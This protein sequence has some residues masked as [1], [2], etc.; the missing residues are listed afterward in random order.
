VSERAAGWVAWSASGLALAFIACAVALSTLNGGSQDLAFL[1]GEATGAL[2]GGLV[3]SRQPRNPVGW[4]IIGHAL[5]FTFGEFARQYAIYGILTEPGSLPAARAMASP[6]YWVWFPGLMLLLVF[7]PLYFPNGRLLSP[8]WR[9]VTWFA[10]CVTV[11]ATGSSAVRPEDFETRGIPNPLG[12]ESLEAL[13]S[14]PDVLAIA[15]PVSWVS[16]GFVAATSLLVRFLRSGGEG[17]QQIKWFAYAIVLLI[18][19]TA[20]DVLFRTALPPLVTSV[21][22]TAVLVSPW[23]AIAVAIFRYRLY[24][25]DI[26]INRTLVYGLLTAMLVLT[27]LGTVMLLQGA[28][29]ALT[30]GGS[31]L[32][33][34]ASTLAI[35]ALFG[36]LRRRIQRLIDRRFYREKYDAAKT[37][38]AFSDRLRDA[39]DL[40]TLSD[41]LVTVIRETVQPE[42]ASLWLRP[43]GGRRGTG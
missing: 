15:L 40:D 19:F 41:D 39:T 32:A 2:V 37:L 24:D 26:L 1:I 34:V 22:L 20:A 5:F 33:I 36:P 38:E 7:L 17:R 21:G 23:V 25:I 16:L 6:P 18:S 4:F 31:Q 3:A 28:L 11:I 29:R 43:T 27:Y 9:P 14:L 30:G 12:I 35:A 42:H 10:A 13:G 8:R